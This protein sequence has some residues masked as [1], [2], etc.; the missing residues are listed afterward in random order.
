MPLVRFEIRNEFE[1]GDPEL[2]RGSTVQAE[3]PK[4]ILDGVAVAGLVGILRQ[5]GDVAEF[6]AE[7]FHGLHEQVMS[8]SSRGH[9]LLARIKQIE[10]T[11]PSIEDGARGKGSCIDLAYE[12]GSSWHADL[13]TTESHLCSSALPP[14][15]MDS[16]EECQDPPRLYLLDKYDSGGIGACIKKYSDPS[17][18]KRAWSTSEN[19]KTQIFQR[20]MNAD[21]SKRNYSWLRNGEVEH[22]VSTSRGNCSLASST[23]FTSLS[24]DEQSFSAENSTT[25]EMRSKP[26]V[27]IGSPLLN[28]TATK[29]IYTENVSENPSN[30]IDV[31]EYNRSSGF[32]LNDNHYRPD[33]SQQ[34]NEEHAICSNGDS[35]SDS[36]QNKST[37]PSVI[38]VEKSEK[39][40]IADFRFCD[41]T[42]LL[43]AQDFKSLVGNSERSQ[44]GQES[45]KTRTPDQPNTF[46][47]IAGM[48]G[49][50]SCQ[51]QY[52]EIISDADNYVDALNT[53]EF[54]VETDSDYQAK[55]GTQSL[56]NKENGV[57]E[58]PQVYSISGNEV[59]MHGSEI[60]LLSPNVTNLDSPMTQQIKQPI[61]EAVFSADSCNDGNQISEDNVL[62]ISRTN[63][64]QKPHDHKSSQSNNCGSGSILYNRTTAT[65]LFQ[66]S[67]SASIPDNPST[68][69]WTNGYLLGLEPSKPPEI[70]LPCGT[71]EIAESNKLVNGLKSDKHDMANGPVQPKTT[72]K[73]EGSLKFLCSVNQRGLDDHQS[74]N[75]KNYVEEIGSMKFSS[76]YHGS[77]QNDFCTDKQNCEKQSEAT[78]FSEHDGTRAPLMNN[79]NTIIEA[80]QASTN[81]V[82]ME[83]LSNASNM[84]SPS[85]NPVHCLLGKAPVTQT[86]RSTE[87]ELLNICNI[88]TQQ[89]SLVGTHQKR[90]NGVEHPEFCEQNLT[91]KNEYGLL[92]KSNSIG[93]HNSDHSSP[94]LEH[95]K[96][97]FHPMNVLE[98]SS[99]KLEFPEE[100]IE[101][102]SEGIVLPSFRLFPGC[103]LYEQDGVSNSDEDTFCRSYR[104]SSEG[105]ISSCSDSNSELWEQDDWPTGKV[106]EISVDF[107]RMFSP[108]T[109]VSPSRD[110]EQLNLEEHVTGL[111][112]FVCGNV[113]EPFQ[114]G[115][116]EVIPALRSSQTL[117]HH[118][119]SNSFLSISPEDSVMLPPPPPLPPIQWRSPKPTG[120]ITDDKDANIDEVNCS[121]GLH[122]QNTADS[123]R[124]KNINPSLAPF[125]EIGRHKKMQYDSSKSEVHLQPNITLEVDKND[126][127]KQPS[128]QM[129]DKPL[130][131]LKVVQHMYKE[132]SNQAVD[133]RGDLLH[134]IRSKVCI[135]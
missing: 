16:Y 4:A 80:H 94:P 102:N 44:T 1:L 106:N 71:G 98:I 125:G 17:Y 85:L 59:V 20:A 97:S 114:S 115:Q 72:R 50:S 77:Q 62:N 86:D 28:S 29:L 45:T 120:G 101:E 133:K 56:W 35:Q 13:R 81:A 87:Y 121:G 103:V 76:T 129:R 116:F 105:L 51:N 104:Y 43:G 49:N 134:Q 26:V 66:L 15:M 112:D 39:M 27:M 108:T 95:M 3:G 14:F 73:V 24:P 32:N 127:R 63:C 42:S 67:P 18:F 93:S 6:A 117:A 82:H 90:L 92:K 100:A 84:A 128:H 37:S 99:L 54:E 47:V 69:L 119:I 60:K 88:Q 7:I 118:G 130:N 110:F 65:S 2:Y 124:P 12:S 41:N 70:S 78:S 91:D 48:A 8:T 23:R 53:L 30:M 19:Q 55:L 132:S 52:D 83:G 126:R 107:Q 25:F 79:S 21:K 5:L 122:Q 11:I 40:K 58:I 9:R 38:W 33:N 89:K 131:S 34:H 74:I 31:L 96:M 109:S 10:A 123:L 75:K 57:A 61:S 46:P 68:K 113:M 64:F 22:V 36:P 111:K 135:H